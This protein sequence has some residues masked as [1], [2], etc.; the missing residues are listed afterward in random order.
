LQAGIL[1]I[2]RT[3]RQGE[4]RRAVAARRARLR[5]EERMISRELLEIL[6]CPVCK[7]DLEYTQKPE[8]LTCHPCR[9]A[10][11]VKDDIPIMLPEEAEH[12]DA[13]PRRE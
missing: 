9:L 2:R 1:R 6:V 10:Y 11:A 7:G 3:S 8:R 12:L 4:R 13:E 5:E